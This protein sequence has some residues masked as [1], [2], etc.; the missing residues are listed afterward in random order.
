MKKEGEG[1][2]EQ[3]RNTQNDSPTSIIV[4]IIVTLV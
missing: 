1:V 2:L 4:V 3:K